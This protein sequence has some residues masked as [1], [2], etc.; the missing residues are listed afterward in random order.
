[1]PNHAVWR[2]ADANETAAAFAVALQSKSS[3]S[4]LVLSRQ[5]TAVL[6]G[7]SYQGA[8]CGAYI[9]FDSAPTSRTDGVMIATGS[10]VA[11]A[12]EAAQTLAEHLHIIVVSMP[13]WSQFEQQS[14]AYRS[15]V[16]PI[17]RTKTMS[18]EAASSFGWARY[19]D[20]SV[21]V[22]TFG[23][24]GPGSEVMSSFGFTVDA[25]AKRFQSALTQAKML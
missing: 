25:I 2:P 18:V 23:R 20:H 17:S 13:C 8:K 15:S 11:L 3:P 4:T 24:S 14:W 16:L 19:A 1:M 5:K 6:P 12:V 9:V 21:S 22:D 7:S 10:E